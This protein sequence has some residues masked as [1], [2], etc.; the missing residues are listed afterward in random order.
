MATTVVLWWVL[1]A[2]HVSIPPAK[3]ATIKLY[4]GLHCSFLR[5][6]IERE[7]ATIYS[8]IKNAKQ[9]HIA[10]I[11][12]VWLGP[13]HLFKFEMSKIIGF[14]HCTLSLLTSFCRM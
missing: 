3:I 13:L 10:F 4:C 14:C 12:W 7:N 2:P 8:H 11:L 1:A 5:Y 9:V 6:L